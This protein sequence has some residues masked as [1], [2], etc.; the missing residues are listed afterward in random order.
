M[1]AIITTFITMALLSPILCKSYDLVNGKQL[2]VSGLKSKE[3]YIFYIEVIQYY[4]AKFNLTTKFTGN[5]NFLNIFVYEYSS[6]SSS[7]YL[8]QKYYREIPSYTYNELTYSLNYLII[9]EDTK[10][11]AIEII[12][13]Y[14]MDYMKITANLEIAAYELA[15]DVTKSI[16][17]LRTGRPYYIFIKSSESQIDL[18]KITNFKEK[19]S[20]LPYLNVYEYDKKANQILESAE[21]YKY[22]YVD[23]KKVASLDYSVKKI[24]HNMLL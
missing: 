22:S 6:R 19:I 11:L 21:Y 5:I 4:E 16:N 17:I 3:N 24:I 18:F 20:Y 2:L 10:F 7:S 14:D 9:Q 13:D 1:K 12:P 23:N 15:N 8:N